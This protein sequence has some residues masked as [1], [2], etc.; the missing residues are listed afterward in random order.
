MPGFSSKRKHKNRKKRKTVEK[1]VKR[2]Y[3][4]TMGKMRTARPGSKQ[5][6]CVF[7]EDVKI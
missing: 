6:N 3:I 7:G 4:N 2:Y 5:L 1:W